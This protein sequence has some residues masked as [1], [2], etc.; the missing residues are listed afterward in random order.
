MI[1]KLNDPRRP[2]LTLLGFP[3]RPMELLKEPCNTIVEEMR[4]R[5]RKINYYQHLKIYGY[6][7]PYHNFLMTQEHKLYETKKPI[8]EGHPYPRPE[9]V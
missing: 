2:I 8:R 4:R 9:P 6:P 5:R 7:E 1:E 3:A